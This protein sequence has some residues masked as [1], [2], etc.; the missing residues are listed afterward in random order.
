MAKCWEKRGCDEEMMA[1]CAHHTQLHDRCPTKCVFAN[2]CQLETHEVC[3]DAALLFDPTIDRS[4][5]IKE[6]CLHC[7]FFLTNGPRL[8]AADDG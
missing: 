1:E 3:V 5:V 7:M 4:E 6:T 2:T 8:T